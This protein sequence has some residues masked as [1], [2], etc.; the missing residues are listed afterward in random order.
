MKL[1][2]SSYKIGN[3]SEVLKQW[4][5]E[6]DNKICLIP[7]SRDVYEDGERKTTGIQKD[8]DSLT[9]LG[10]D[11]HLLDLRN[12][13]GKKDELEEVFKRVH[14][15]YV[16][17]GNTF[18]LRKAMY[19]SGFDELLLQYANNDEYLYSGYSAGICLLSK[20][21]RAVAIMDEADKDPYNSGLPPIY[22]GIGFVDEAIIPHF[23]SDHSDSDKATEAVKYCEEN[24]LPYITLHDGD[25]IVKDLII[26]NEKKIR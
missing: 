24:N 21:M 20:D 1:Y 3:K 22:E 26:S 5:E 14:S 19:L 15:F 4:I 11:V 23:E 6:H 17:G 12:Y 8:A 18:A 9:E 2:L 13:F 25:V 16:I 7:N 10:F